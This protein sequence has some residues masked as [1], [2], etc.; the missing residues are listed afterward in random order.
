MSSQPLESRV[1]RLEGAYEQVDRRLDSLDRRFEALDR[2]L[3]DFRAEV[4]R[5]FDGLNWRMTSL[6]LGTWVTVMLAIFFHRV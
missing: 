6:I 2:K 1:S 5:R 3:D 4:E